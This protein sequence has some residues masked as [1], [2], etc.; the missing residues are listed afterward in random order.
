MP[1]YDYKCQQCGKVT[2]IRH[3]FD[4]SH[5]DPCP[6]CGG[7][8]KRVFSAAPI[9]FKGSGYYVTDSRKKNPAAAPDGGSSEA[10]KPAEKPA[11]SAAPAAKSSE[12]AA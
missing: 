6:A 9:V 5:A 11:E 7:A 10:S 2:E 1:L 8:L 3:G 4:E 12:P